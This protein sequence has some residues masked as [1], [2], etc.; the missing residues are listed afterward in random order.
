MTRPAVL[1]TDPAAWRAEALEVIERLAALGVP[2]GAQ[3]LRE[4][5]PTP[6]H[7]PN[8]YGAVFR[9]ARDRG[10]IQRAGYRVSSTRTRRGGTQ[11]VWVGTNPTTYCKGA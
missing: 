1:E 10:L 11:A 8:Q 4:R 2:F 9:V 6:P 3:S 7:H 5:L